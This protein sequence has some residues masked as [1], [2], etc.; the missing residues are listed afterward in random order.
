MI[1]PKEIRAKAERRYRDFLLSIVKNENFFPL[2]IPFAKV[3]PGEA[4]SRWA[5]LRGEFEALRLMSSE[6]RPGASYM[7]NWEERQDRLAGTQLF[8]TRIAFADEASFLVFLG[9]RQEC[10]RFREDLRILVGA[11]PN[12]VEWVVSKPEELIRHKGEWEDIAAVLRWF[13]Q[14]PRSGLYLREVPAVSDTKFIESR[15]PLFESLLCALRHPPAGAPEAGTSEFRMSFEEKHGLRIAMPLVRLRILDPSIAER[16][17]SGIDDMAI[18]VDRFPLIDFEEIERVLVIENKTSFGRAEVF[19]TAPALRGTIA[20]FGSGYAT[21][22][23]SSISWIETR[24]ISYWGDIDS[25]GLRILGAFRSVFPRA[26][27]LLMDEAVFDKFPEFHS[28]SP[29]DDADEPKGLTI[30]EISLFRRLVS[31]SS[32]NRLEQERIPIQFVRSRLEEWWIKTR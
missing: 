17:F 23:L 27:A 26:E 5:D 20:I 15:K 19:L 7:V 1:G 3:K 16:R 29:A 2:D 12:L 4:V 6:T 14:N 25:H 10:E 30:D 9:K 13:I 22:A 31:L 28:D 18:P 21:S 24:R 8:P 11:F 32:K